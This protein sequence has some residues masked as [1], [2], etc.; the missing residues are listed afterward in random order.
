MLGSNAPGNEF[1]GYKDFCEA[2][3][4]ALS[5]DWAEPSLAPRSGA[6]F[7]FQSPYRT[8]QWP[9]TGGRLTRATPDRSVLFS[10]ECT[11]TP[12]PV[13]PTGLSHTV[14]DWSIAVA[15]YGPLI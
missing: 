1:R 10:S 14:V 2:F 5:V 6:R 15:V 4:G 12:R 8:L 11:F 3:S 9:R 7:G 13:S